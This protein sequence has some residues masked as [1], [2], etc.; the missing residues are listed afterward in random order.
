MMP[1]FVVLAPG[2]LNHIANIV[3]GYAIAVGVSVAI[4]FV[5]QW[6]AHRQRERVQELGAR[7]KAIYSGYL[8]TAMQHPHLAE[9]MVGGLD[10]AAE[11]VRYRQFV[12]QLLAAAD[13]I[14]LLVPTPAWK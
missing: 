14:L 12:A 4:W 5:W 7:T 8:R 11:Q 6:W 10:S 1:L 2:S 13:E 3:K 9:P